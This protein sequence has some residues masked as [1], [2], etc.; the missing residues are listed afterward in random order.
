MFTLNAELVEKVIRYYTVTCGRQVDVEGVRFMATKFTGGFVNS[1][2]C[3]DAFKC[4]I[5]NAG[6][7][8]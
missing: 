2:D 1:S 8:R 3:V 7:V 4:R 5:W 6:L